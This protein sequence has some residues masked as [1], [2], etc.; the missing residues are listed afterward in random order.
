MKIPYDKRHEQKARKQF[1]KNTYG[2]FPSNPKYLYEEE[3]GDNS[4]WA[5]ELMGKIGTDIMLTKLPKRQ[6]E[7]FELKMA[8]LNTLGIANE[9]G[10][11]ESAVSQ[12]LC[13]G[14]KVL[15]R[16]CA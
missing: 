3:T 11:K 16:F 9:M 13:R 12:L 7:A 2:K 15:K 5:K 4:G 10:I 1:N 6:R 8:G 14:R